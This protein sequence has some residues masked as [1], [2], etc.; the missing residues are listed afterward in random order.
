[1]NRAS[2]E[3]LEGHEYSELSNPSASHI[4][5]PPQGALGSDQAG[6]SATSYEGEYNRLQEEA[7][8]ALAAVQP[9]VGEVAQTIGISGGRVTNYQERFGIENKEVATLA[10]RMGMFMRGELDVKDVGLMVCCIGPTVD[11][12]LEANINNRAVYGLGACVCCVGGERTLEEEIAARKLVA[13]KTRTKLAEKE[14]RAAQLRAKIAARVKREQEG[15][16]KRSFVL[17]KG[18]M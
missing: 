17:S 11:N 7:L 13:E 18:A 1:M 5:A 6:S 2:T 16:K 15:A 9:T 14:Q 10:K 8:A 3:A 4:P 12:K